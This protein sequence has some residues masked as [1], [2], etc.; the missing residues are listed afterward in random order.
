MKQENLDKMIKYLSKTH[1]DVLLVDSF[2]FSNEDMDEIILRLGR[3]LSFLKA[4][5]GPL[6]PFKNRSV[7]KFEKE[8]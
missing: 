6:D 5:R 3:K 4:I 2:R 7:H 1:T 8:E